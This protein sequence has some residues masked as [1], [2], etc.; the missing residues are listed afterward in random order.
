MMRMETIARSTAAAG[1]RRK[2][3]SRSPAK[4][5]LIAGGI[6]AADGQSHQW[7]AVTVKAALLHF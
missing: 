1:G 2:I 4:L 5:W 3:S 6:A 7:Y